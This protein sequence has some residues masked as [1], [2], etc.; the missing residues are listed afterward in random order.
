MKHSLAFLTVVLLS[1]LSADEV[2]SADAPP[3]GNGALTT[4]VV[5]VVGNHAMALGDSVGGATV[6]IRDTETGAIL[7]SGTQT[8]STGDLRSVMQTPREHIEQIYS[9][10]GAAAFTATLHLTKPTVVEVTGEGPLKFPRAKRRASKTVLLYPGKD[11]TGDGI[12]LVLYGLIVRIESPTPDRPLGIGDGVTVR[13]TVNMM[14]DCV[15]EPFGNWDSRKMELYGEVRNGETVIG[16][17]EF[18]HQGP[19]GLFQGEYT[20]PRSLKGKDR[21]TLRVMASDKE[22]MNIGYDEITYHLVPWEQSRDATGR[23][24]PPIGK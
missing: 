23:E 16:R 7:A 14:C 4:I 1:L 24:I 13:T 22:G 9:V 17:V 12:V 11:V 5:R 10:K 20:I 19:K 3:Q 8:G 21:L 15:V 6:T 2:R 18:F